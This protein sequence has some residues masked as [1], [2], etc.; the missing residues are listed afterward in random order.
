[1]LKIMA[2]FQTLITHFYARMN[3][4]STTGSNPMS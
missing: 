1:M 4:N 3:L 2:A